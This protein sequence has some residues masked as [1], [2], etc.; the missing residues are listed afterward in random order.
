MGSEYYILTFS[1][2]DS[3][4][5]VAQVSSRIFGSGGNILESHQFNDIENDLFFMRTTFRL[6]DDTALDAFKTGFA[7]IAA[8]RGMDWQIHAGSERRKVL[9]LAS[10]SDHCLVDLLY[11]RRIGELVMDI[12]GIISNHPRETYVGT[13]F[14]DIPFHHLPITPATK[15]TQEARIWEIFNQTGADLVVLA[16]YMQI[17][18]ADLVEKFSGRCGC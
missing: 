14:G 3:P 4:G 12:S 7:T 16:R 2:Q 11:R 6:A 8:E 9:I 1:C 13:D 5:I 18:S 17:L 10:K 15:A